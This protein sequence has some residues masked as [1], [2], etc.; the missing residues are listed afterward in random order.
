M[1]DTL[2]YNISID[3]TSQSTSGLTHGANAF[4]VN[5]NIV[6]NNST[7]ILPDPSL[8]YGSII[9]FSVPCFTV[10]LIQFL[11]NT[12]V[13]NINQMNLDMVGILQL[14]LFQISQLLWR[15]FCKNFCSGN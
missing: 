15:F 13:S 11:V 4:A 3:N 5:P 2:Y 6:A 8:Y 9:R 7:P 12:P 1:S 14:I 10:P